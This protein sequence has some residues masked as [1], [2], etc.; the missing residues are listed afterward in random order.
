MLTVFGYNEQLMD[1]IMSIV[2]MNLPEE[3]M[4]MV[5]PIHIKFGSRKYY[6]YMGFVT[7]PF[8]EGVIWNEFHKVFSSLPILSFSG[9]FFH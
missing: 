3:A 7:T 8:T 9:H 5:N 1:E 2:D 6:C 4:G